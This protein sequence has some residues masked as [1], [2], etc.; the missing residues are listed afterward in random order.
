MPTCYR[1]LAIL[2]VVHCLI[3]HKFSLLDPSLLVPAKTKKILKMNLSIWLLP[4]FNTFSL[5]SLPKGSSVWL[6]LDEKWAPSRENLSSGFRQ[7]KTPTSL[8]SHRSLLEAWNFRY[9]ETSSIILSRQQ[10]T[11]VPTR[12]RGCAGFICTFVVRISHDAAHIVSI[13]KQH[14]LHTIIDN[15]LSIVPRWLKQC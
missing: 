13:R 4:C 1:I 3:H 7:G 15:Q 8:C 14:S 5:I 9:K 11:K 12:L 10:T 2:C 6:L